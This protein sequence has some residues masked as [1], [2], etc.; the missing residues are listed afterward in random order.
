MHVSPLLF[1][2]KT[3]HTLS[4]RWPSVICTIGTTG[5]QSSTKGFIKDHSSSA[6]SKIEETLL[7]KALQTTFGNKYRENSDG[8]QGRY[9]DSAGVPMLPVARRF[10]NGEA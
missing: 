3:V 5:F 10:F 7:M 8:T 6:Q 2:V 1:S 4:V 9:V